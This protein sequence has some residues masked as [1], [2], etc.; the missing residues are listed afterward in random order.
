MVATVETRRNRGDM[1]PYVA[2]IAAITFVY[3]VYTDFWQ[4][5]KPSR[6]PLRLS[7]LNIVSA[8]TYP[9]VF[10]FSVPKTPTREVSFVY[11]QGVGRKDAAD[12]VAALAKYPMTLC[13]SDSETP[14]LRTWVIRTDDVML[15][16]SD[17][18]D[19]NTV[20]CHIA[21]GGDTV[22]SELIE[23]AFRAGIILRRTTDIIES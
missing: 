5:M 7:E 20:V 8:G 13:P 3:C 14:N 4:N 19:T 12:L 11:S 1:Y 23:I 10:M 16:V 21:K 9:L 6:M 17:G 15:S 2:L 22:R 18:F